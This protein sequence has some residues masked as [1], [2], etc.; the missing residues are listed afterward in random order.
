M[1]KRLDIPDFQV[2]F[3]NLILINV[4][5]LKSIPIKIYIPYFKMG[6]HGNHAFPQKETVKI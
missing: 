3:L 5:Y 1:N 2:Q 6:T 4:V